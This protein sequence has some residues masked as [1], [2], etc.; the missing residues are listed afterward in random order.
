MSRIFVDVTLP[1]SERL[2][3]WP[4]DPPVHVARM[5]DGLPM[6]S[7]LSMSVHAGTHIDAP[8]HFLPGGAGWTTCRWMS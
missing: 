1:I 5:V 2:S 7:G 3:V 6:V 8:A 4:G